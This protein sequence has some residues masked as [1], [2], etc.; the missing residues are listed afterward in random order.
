LIFNLFILKFLYEIIV[1]SNNFFIFNWNFIF[2]SV[3]F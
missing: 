2:S 1:I 3:Y